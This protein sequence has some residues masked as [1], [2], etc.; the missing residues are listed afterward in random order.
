MIPAWT[1]RAVLMN[2]NRWPKSYH[3]FRMR[4]YYPKGKAKQRGNKQFSHFLLRYCQQADGR[5]AG[6]DPGGNRESKVAPE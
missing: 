1:R 2:A 4:G 3:D 5:S 6:A